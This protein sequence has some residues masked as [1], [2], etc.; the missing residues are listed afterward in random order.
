MAPRTPDDTSKSDGEIE[1]LSEEDTQPQQ[2]IIDSDS[3]EDEIIID[4]KRDRKKKKHR[5]HKEKKNKHKKKEKD[6]ERDEE[7]RE[8]RVRGKEN[9]KEGN[10]DRERED[11]H[12]EIGNNRDREV[13]RHKE[14][15]RERYRETERN[16]EIERNRVGERNRENE[17]FREGDRDRGIDRHR[18]VDRERDIDR[19][20]GAERDREIDRH[21]EGDRDRERLREREGERNRQGNEQDDRHNDREANRFNRDAER[22]RYREERRRR[23]EERGRYNEGERY[24]RDRSR[25]RE[26]SDSSYNQ[27]NKRLREEGDERYDR[28]RGRRDE[29]KEE[30]IDEGPPPELDLED[31]EDENEMIERRRIERKKFYENMNIDVNKLD[32]DSPSESDINLPITSPSEEVTQQPE[33]EEVAE[34]SQDEDTKTDDI[35][36]EESKKN[37]PEQLPSQSPPPNTDFKPFRNLDMF[38]EELTVDDV[39]Q[40]DYY[41]TT[42]MVD[43]WD[44]SDGYYKVRIGELLD[45]RYKV[46]D[47]TGRGVFSS[48]VRVR[49]E[50]RDKQ[51][52]AIKIIRNN[53]VMKNAG[54]K[55]FEVLKKL[56]DTDPED[57]YHC[58]R[59]YRSFYHKDH[60]CLVIE[61]LGMNLREVLKRYGKDVGLHIKAIKS[62]SYQLLLALKLLKK[63]A[64]LHADIKP[65]NILINESK[66]TLKLCDFGSA[67]DM[68]ECDIAPYLVSRFYRAPEIIM[69]MQYGHNIDLWSTAVT[70]CELYT[71]SVMFPGKSNNEMLKLFMDFKGKLPGKLINKGIFRDQHFDNSNNFLYHEIDKITIKEKTTVVTNI[72]PKGELLDFRSSEHP[73]KAAQLKEFLEKLLMLDPSKRLPL[74]KALSHPFI[75]EKVV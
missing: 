33:E 58:M 28:K 50:A 2:I 46:Y 65:D 40:T 25:K 11:R 64:I 35:N 66:A 71:G 70:I 31:S 47:I 21:R 74:H 45:K 43:N 54:L 22:E 37:S 41:E 23:D 42:D 18:E 52:A 32:T 68:T 44:D 67:S 59:L 30:E 17:R 4:T 27:R 8:A 29:K 69:G 53:K 60:L 9:Y 20:R 38:S 61:S 73:K 36:E 3:D 55:E 7:R 19:H 24:E 6:D 10:R 34:V 57:K 14:G 1:D 13:D 26:R 49:N 62:Y 39:H 51:E 63:C 15:E 5:R 56:N 75:T 12:H 48:V 72:A 16:R